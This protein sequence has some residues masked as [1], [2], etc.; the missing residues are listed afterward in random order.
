MNQNNFTAVDIEKII[1]QNCSDDPNSSAARLRPALIR[2]AAERYAREGVKSVA[3]VRAKTDTLVK[4]YPDS[5]LSDKK[6]KATRST[7]PRLK[8]KPEF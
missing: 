3:E 7:E 1:R 6:M 8:P 4:Q 5:T 2:L